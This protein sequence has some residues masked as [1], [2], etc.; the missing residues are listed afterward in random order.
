MIIV[1]NV[2][3]DADD[4]K[5]S[6]LHQLEIL[7]Q[8]VSFVGKNQYRFVAAINKDFQATYLHLFPDNKQ[9]YVNASTIEHAEISFEYHCRREEDLMCASAARH[10][11]LSTLKYLQSYGYKWD[12]RTI[13]KALKH[14]HLHILQYLHPTIVW[15]D[16]IRRRHNAL[17]F[18]HVQL[19]I[20]RSTMVYNCRRKDATC[21]EAARHDH[22][23]ILLGEK[24]KGYEWN[25][26]PCAMASCTGTCS[27]NLKNYRLLVALI[28]FCTLNVA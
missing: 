10:G 13:Y 15:D 23:E 25:E 6:P 4:K 19:E 21:S 28:L 7:E 2:V 26:L 11:S 18:V 24:Y 20:H 9:T 14:G 3:V 8:I 17:T 12:L 27:G 16:Y 22:M 1:H 5:R